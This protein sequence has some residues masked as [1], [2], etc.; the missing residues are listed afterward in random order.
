[1][2]RPGIVLLVVLGCLALPAAAP[3]QAQ[4]QLSAAQFAA[5]DAVYV[6]FAPFEDGATTAER[7]AAR[8]ACTS[9]GSA[10]ALLSALRRACFAQLTIGQTLGQSG[11]CKGRI[12]CLVAVRAVQRAAT[13][14]LA[15]ARAANRVVVELGIAPACSRELRRSAAELRYV[16]RLRSL[17]AQLERA[18]RTRSPRLATR[19]QRGLDALKSP[20]TRTAAQQ[21]EDFRAGCA[22]PG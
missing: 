9:L 6:A 3:A 4:A 14:Y 20:D 11:R 7:A 22:P 18:L 16:T 15:A 10:D 1:M 12:P 13:R 21:R 19:A 5:I 2:R 17:F 8:A